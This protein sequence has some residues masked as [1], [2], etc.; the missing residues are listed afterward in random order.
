MANKLTPLKELELFF[1]DMIT[2]LLELEQDHVLLQYAR[3]GQPASKINENYVYVRVFPE[4]DERTIYKNR[5]VVYNET[6]GTRAIQQ[7]A[8]RTLTLG[9]IFYGPDCASNAMLFNEKLYLPEQKLVLDQQGLFLVPDRTFGPTRN[10]E[11]HN[12]QWFERADMEH[13]F[14]EEVIVEE[15]VESFE[16]ADIRMEVDY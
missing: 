14:Y 12:G 8:Q 16:N 1:A 13:R 6:D 11:F 3:Q 10:P 9:T 4:N 7:H 15:K 5:K 2:S